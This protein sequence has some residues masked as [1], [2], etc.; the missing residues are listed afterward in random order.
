MAGQIGHDGGTPGPEEGRLLARPGPPTE[1]VSP[2]LH[3]LGLDRDRD[4]L[5]LVPAGCKKQDT[6]LLVELYGP[7]APALQPWQFRALIAKGPPPAE[8]VEQ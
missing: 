3:A 6:I 7:H 4:A 8:A 5:L 2:G 1:T